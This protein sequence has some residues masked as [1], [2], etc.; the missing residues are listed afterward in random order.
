MRAEMTAGSLPSGQAPQ[1]VFSARAVAHADAHANRIRFVVFMF[2]SS[3]FLCRDDGKS[4]PY[5]RRARGRQFRQ[6]QVTGDFRTSGT[7]EPG[8]ALTGPSA[9]FLPL[10][11]TFL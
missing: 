11:V 2:V 7:D 10:S 3:F 6:S 5:F 4:I 1:Q 8:A 9:C